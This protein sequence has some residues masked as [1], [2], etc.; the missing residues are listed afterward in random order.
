MADKTPTIICEPTTTSDEP[1]A[2]AQP[3]LP[4][5]S[6]ERSG[7]RLRRSPSPQPQ[8]NAAR[9]LSMLMQRPVQNEKFMDI[10]L[11]PVVKKQAQ[12]QMAEQKESLFMKVGDRPFVR[13]SHGSL[14]FS[15][16]LSLFMKWSFVSATRCSMSFKC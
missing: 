13:P 11:K 16:S 2:A 5:Q 7:D 10:Q 9:R 1:V 4:P 14:S 8:S 15:V 3:Q 12:P 6:T